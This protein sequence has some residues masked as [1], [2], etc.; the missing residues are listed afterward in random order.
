VTLRTRIA[1]AAGLAVAL[2]VIAAAIAVYLGVRGELRGEVDESLR[3]RAD[4]IAGR[5]GDWRGPGGAPFDGPPGVGDGFPP[6]GPP[7]RFGGP[8]GYVPLILPSGQ[9]LRR[10]GGPGGG[11]RRDRGGDRRISRRAQ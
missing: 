10:R 5:V 7:E 9:V 6:V 2:A 4:L 11:A 8:E 1:A 3:E